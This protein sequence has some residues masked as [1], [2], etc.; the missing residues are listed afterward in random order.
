[1]VSAIRMHFLLS[2]PSRYHS[3]DAMCAHSVLHIR[4]IDEIEQ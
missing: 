1:M 3:N 2:L 4:L